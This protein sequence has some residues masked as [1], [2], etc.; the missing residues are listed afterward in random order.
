ML[1]LP[2]GHLRIPALSP[3]GGNPAE[4]AEHLEEGGR[5]WDLLRKG[6]DALGGRQQFL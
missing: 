4:V 6:A 1:L 2:R 3:K 5:C